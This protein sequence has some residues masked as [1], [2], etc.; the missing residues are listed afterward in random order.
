MKI[1]PKMF[2]WGLVVLLTIF[3]FTGF[4]FAD[5]GYFYNNLIPELTGIAV[6]LIVILIVFNYWQESSKKEKLITIER[7]LREY[8]IFFLRHN[9]NNLPPELKVGRFY[10]VDHGKNQ[11]TLEQLRL[12]I[13]HDGLKSAN[14]ETIIKYCKRDC[15]TLENLLP[16]AAELTNEHF[17]SW[18]R[19]VFFINNIAKNTTSVEQDVMDIIQNI[20]RFDN[21]STSHKLYVG[22]NDV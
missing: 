1:S 16:V 21:A 20:K 7:R 14:I 8:L 3:L 6:E 10:G 5:A 12:H 22:A 18:S 17:K 9:F 19:I 4:T 11:E 2:L 13:K 15:T